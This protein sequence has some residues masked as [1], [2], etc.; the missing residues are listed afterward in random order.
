MLLV[1]AVNTRIISTTKCLKYMYV[2]QGCNHRVIFGNSDRGDKE[3]TEDHGDQKVG[4]QTS[5]YIPFA[6]NIK[7]FRKDDDVDT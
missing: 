3:E 2:S 4:L 7:A 6:Q 5:A 1:N